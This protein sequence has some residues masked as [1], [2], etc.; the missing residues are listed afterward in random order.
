MK[1]FILCM[2][3]LFA[4][5]QVQKVASPEQPRNEPVRA[6]DAPKAEPKADD[7][8]PS[9]TEAP[10]DDPELKNLQWNRYVS[11]N[12]VILSIDDEKGKKFADNIEL[13]KKLALTRWGFP[14][15][16]FSRECRVFCV[17]SYSLLKKLFN[18]SSSRAQDRKD[19][20]A[21]W[22]V[23]DDAPE[24]SAMPFIT[25][26]ALGELEIAEKTVLPFWFKRGAMVLNASAD[27]VRT[28][29]ASQSV[30]VRKEQF[31]H[32]A[33]QLLVSTE[34]E[35]NKQSAESKKLYDVQAAG[36]CLLLRKEFGEAKLQGF[37]RILSRNKPDVAVETVY[38]FKDL[39]EF[40]NS[41]MTFMKELC[42]DIV[43][44]K[45]PNAYLTITPAKK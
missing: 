36:L 2:S 12:F 41:Y 11:K 15:V 39:T 7:P 42:L 28:A 20:N 25:Q 1:P 26:V 3:L 40:G 9:I 5:S 23:L 31:S 8:M 37:L 35:Y 21:I 18:L 30:V 32:T 14:D 34:E 10:L 44:N 29:F 4:P 6:Q 17:P 38:G 45:T 33:E 24:N 16:Q 19:L 13:Y 43:Y 27:S 22:L